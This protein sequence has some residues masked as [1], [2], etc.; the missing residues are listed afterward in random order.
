MNCPSCKE[1]RT[2]DD[3]FCMHC[4]KALT[5]DERRLSVQAQ[6]AETMSRW[7]DVVRV[8][9]ELVNTLETADAKA[10]QHHLIGLVQGEQLTDAAAATVSLN[11]ALDLDPSRLTAFEALDRILSKAGDHAAQADAY[12]VMLQRATA[13]GAPDTV[14][15]ALARN[16]GELF[17]TRLNDPEKASMAYGM[18]LELNPDDAASHRAMA[19]LQEA[20]GDHGRAIIHQRRA[21]ELEPNGFESYQSLRHLFF[22]E[23]QYD[24]GWCLCRVLSVLG[25]ASSEEVDFYERYATSTPTRA[26]RALQQA[27]WSLIDHSGQSQL[28]NALFER[29][30]DTISSVM[31]VSTRQLGLKRRRDFIDLGAASRFTNVIGYLFDHLPVPHAETYRSSQMRGMRPALLEPPVMLA[32]PAVMDHDLFTMAFIGGRY[33]SMLRPA[34]LVVSSVVDAK[35]RVACAH[36]VVDTIRDLVNPKPKKGPHFDE[37]L[38]D[39][40]S[41]N[42]SKSEIQSLKKLVTKMEA[43]PDF[44]FDVAHW[45]RCLD[46]TCD[47]IGFIFA[48][49]LEKPLSLMRVE[50]PKSAVATVA[51]R[52]DALV[53]FAFSD[54]YMQVRRLIGHN[55]D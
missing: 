24:A 4:G 19:G 44:H 15:A 41:R 42:L 39:A 2:E 40:L 25:Q 22:A 38:S 23:K 9:G 46:F 8:R 31:A 52:I 55:I 53:S 30:F 3:L 32:N 26:E 17:S 18:V 48:N 10:E 13:N 27:H 35:A 50:D 49:N 54:E 37:Q 14:V 36:K 16:M 34:F 21:I 11:R 5:D 1:S 45:L 43:N 28:L 12:E 29:V 33:L 20:Q 47:R 7:T 6:R 51:E